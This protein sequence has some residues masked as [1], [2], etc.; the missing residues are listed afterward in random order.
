MVKEIEYNDEVIKIIVTLNI[1]HSESS[2]PIHMIELEIPT[3]DPNKNYGKNHCNDEMIIETSESLIIKGMKIIDNT[4][5]ENY[6]MD[7]LINHG[8][9]KKIN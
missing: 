3:L 9:K 4:Q 6:V 1:D 8:F 5:N 2:G 7:L